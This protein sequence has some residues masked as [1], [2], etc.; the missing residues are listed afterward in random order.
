MQAGRKARF[1]QILNT[2]FK[3]IMLLGHP[4]FSQYHFN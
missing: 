2:K 3:K 4:F 1:D